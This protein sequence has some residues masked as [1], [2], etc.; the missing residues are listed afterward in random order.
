MTEND[1][2][3]ILEHALEITSGS[4]GPD[5]LAENVLNWDSMGHL[6]ILVALDKMFEG[7]VAEISEIAEANSVQKIF[8]ALRQYSLI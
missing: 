6:S 7:K 8:A 4:I 1:V 5:A 2:L 3:Q